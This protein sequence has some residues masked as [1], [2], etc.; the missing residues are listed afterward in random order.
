MIS[1]VTLGL[2]LGGA[3][4]GVD[5]L[6]FSLLITFGFVSVCM[7]SDLLRGKSSS[8]IKTV[9]VLALMAIQIVASHAAVN[10]NF[11]PHA[12]KILAFVLG[13]LVVGPYLRWQAVRS[14]AK[15][16]PVVFVTIAAVVLISGKGYF[17]GESE[18]FGIPMFGSPNTTAFVCA[19]S[20]ALTLY[21][22]AAARKARHGLM[23]VWF[24]ALLA[25]QLGV[26]IATRSNGGAVMVCIA[27][28]AFL[29]RRFSPALLGAGMLGLLATLLLWDLN[30]EN[31]DL[32][33]SG[34][35]LIWLD[36]L[37]QWM[38]SP[39]NIIMGVGPGGID[40]E[41]LF[42]EK[43]ISAHSM[44]IETLFTFGLVGMGL[45]VTYVY[46]VGRAV[47]RR[48][49][50]LPHGEGHL[51]LAVFAMVTVGMAFDSYFLAAQ[52]VWLGALVHGIL[53]LATRTSPPPLTNA[54]TVARHL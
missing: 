53:A 9:M 22:L 43:V 10:P 23:S 38:S 35:L 31:A 41:P 52:L 45:L 44:Y 8:L 49:P 50:T 26:I 17:Y 13:A 48:L 32:V 27:L 30:A 15:I 16:F 42:T 3:T 34:R 11:Y 28:A 6:Y 25:A 18:R 33:G 24:L 4:A 7:A 47:L 14:I 40:L 19:L 5:G 51:L 2:L 21:S 29:R 20:V 39:T 1:Y 37:S 46:V 36:L 54:G 12:I